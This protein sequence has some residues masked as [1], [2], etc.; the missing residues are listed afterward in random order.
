MSRSTL[1][2]VPM[3][4][5]EPTTLVTPNTPALTFRIPLAA[6]SGQHVQD[7]VELAAAL[8]DAAQTAAV[9]WAQVPAADIERTLR[10]FERRRSTRCAPLVA[11][12]RENGRRITA[13]HSWLVRC[14]SSLFSP[15]IA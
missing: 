2:W 10:D 6:H 8:R 7:G 4:V 11:E 9:P 14:Q 15:C 1:R 3:A 13:R 12:A 5:M